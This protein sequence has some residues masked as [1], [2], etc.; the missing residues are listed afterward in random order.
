MKILLYKKY[1]KLLEGSTDDT[2][3][4]Y[5]FNPETGEFN[6]TKELRK[7]GGMQRILGVPIEQ[8]DGLSSPKPMMYSWELAEGA[9]RNI[10]KRFPIRKWKYNLL[11]IMG[12]KSR[13][14]NWNIIG[15]YFND[16]VEIIWTWNPAIETMATDGSS[17]AM[18]PAFFEDLLRKCN[19]SYLAVLFVFMHELY[20]N[21]LEH[22]TRR[23]L[24]GG[25]AKSGFGNICAD[26]EVNS[27]VIEDYGANSLLDPASKIPQWDGD[28]VQKL[29]GGYYDPKYKKKS[30][31][32]IMRDLENDPKWQGASPPPPFDPNDNPQNEPKQKRVYTAEEKA[33]IQKGIEAA[34]DIIRRFYLPTSQNI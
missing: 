22:T 23:D 3:K 30:M 1:S 2:L 14:I 31:E 29:I 32:D 11:Q 4:K 20:H 12:K 8:P 24:I 6:H 17:I 25:I 5:G 7:A 15:K 28:F 21:I 27:S 13:D 9:P 34:H 33:I 18:N 10:G 26:Y 19:G 16:L